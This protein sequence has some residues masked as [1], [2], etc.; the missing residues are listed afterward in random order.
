MPLPTAWGCPLFPGLSL[1]YLI[2]AGIKPELLEEE[3]EE[4][5]REEVGGGDWRKRLIFHFGIIHGSS[6]VPFQFP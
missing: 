2:F 4:L 6:P 5:K 1:L 3:V